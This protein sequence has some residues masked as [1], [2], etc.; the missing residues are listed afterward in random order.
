ML[1]Q[2]T[3]TGGRVQVATA[4]GTY[5]VGSDC[6][7]SL[8][9]D[10]TTSS[11][12]GSTGASFQAPSSFRATLNTTPTTTGARTEAGRGALIIQPLNVSTVVGRFVS[13]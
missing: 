13:Q 3:Y 5:T 8:T 1:K 2:W 4:T 11:S 6:N 12:G 10:S 7:L 9:F